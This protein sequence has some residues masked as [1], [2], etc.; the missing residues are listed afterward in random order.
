VAVPSSRVSLCMQ[1]VGEGRESEVRCVGGFHWPGLGVVH[2]TFNTETLFTQPC[3]TAR[4]TE[5]SNPKGT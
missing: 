3:L 1:L 5:K 4:E 2:T